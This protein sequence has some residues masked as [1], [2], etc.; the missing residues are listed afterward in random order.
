MPR[1]QSLFNEPAALKLAS[2]AET[3]AVQ[4]GDTVT[5]SDDQERE[6]GS[7]RH[8]ANVVQSERRVRTSLSHPLR[9]DEVMAGHAGGLIGITFCPGKR[10]SSGR[11]FRWERDLTSDLDVVAQWRADAVVSLIEDHEFRMLGVA[12]LGPKV[13]ARGIEWHHLPIIDVQPPDERFENGWRTSGP[14][15]LGLIR[16]GGRVLVHCRGGLGRAGTVAARMLVELD[17]QPRDAVDRVRKARPGAIETRQQLDHVLNL[18]RRNG[19]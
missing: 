5:H 7:G 19:I 18:P 15:L 8:Q 6:S 16:E 11:G 9:I 10:G 1:D 4:G 17:V 3:D 12:E 14:K 13:R 2:A